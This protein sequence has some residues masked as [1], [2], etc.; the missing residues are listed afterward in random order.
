[1]IPR[2]STSPKLVEIHQQW[3]GITK[4]KAME[5]VISQGVTW[6]CWLSFIYSFVVLLCCCCCCCCWCCCCCCFAEWRLVGFEEDLAPLK[7]CVAINNWLQPLCKYPSNIIFKQRTSINESS[8]SWH[9]LLEASSQGLQQKH[10][11]KDRRSEAPNA[12]VEVLLIDMKSC[13]ANT[14]QNRPTKI[15][16]GTPLAITGRGCGL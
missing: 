8:F 7:S 13:H 16:N 14:P 4:K 10:V 12:H 1:M 2:V 15:N 3:E 6:Y 11:F 5:W 9:C